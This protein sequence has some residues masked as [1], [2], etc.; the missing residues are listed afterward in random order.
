MELNAYFKYTVLPRN[1]YNVKQLSS[2]QN[3][4]TP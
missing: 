1:V 3:D 4:I 2:L